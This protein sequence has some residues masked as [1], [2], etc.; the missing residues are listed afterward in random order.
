MVTFPPTPAGSRRGCFFHLHCENLVEL[1]EVKLTKLLGGCV[2]GAP[3]SFYHSDLS[4]LSLLQF[5]NYSQRFLPQHRF[6]GGFLLQEIMILCICLV[7]SRIL[8]AMV[9]PVTSLLWWVF[10]NFSVCLAFTPC[11][12]KTSR[13]QKSPLCSLF[14]L[15]PSLPAFFFF[16]RGGKLKWSAVVLI[17]RL[18]QAA[19]YCPSSMSFEIRPLIWLSALSMINYVILFRLL[20]FLIILL[21]L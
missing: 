21:C 16:L 3:W 7:G 1:L 8:G 18:L 6:P 10:V 14:P 12:N 2:W 4:T 13:I 17:F 5:S 11:W 20:F 9:C 19:F 15:Y